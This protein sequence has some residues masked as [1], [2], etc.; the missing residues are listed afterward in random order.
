[1]LELPRVS[2]VF[3]VGQ[4]FN[5]AGPSAFDYRV[6]AEYISKQLGVP[7]VEIPNPK[8]HPFEINITRAIGDAWVRDLE[9]L[10]GLEPLAEDSAFREHEGVDPTAISRAVPV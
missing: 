2:S 9:L 8:Y 7:M 1:M 6:A 3:L 5:I 4:A 10:R